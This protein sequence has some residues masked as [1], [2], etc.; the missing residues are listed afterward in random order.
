MNKSFYIWTPLE[1]PKL[2]IKRVERAPM[3]AKSHPK[4]AVT[5]ESVASAIRSVIWLGRFHV[6]FA[7]NCNG[8][9]R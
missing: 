6:P 2:H 5:A 3:C 7:W 4:S 1:S 9:G 8:R